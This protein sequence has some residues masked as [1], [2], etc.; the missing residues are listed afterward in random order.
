MQ[1]FGQHECCPSRVLLIVLPLSLVCL[2]NIFGNTNVFGVFQKVMFLEC[3]QHTCNRS[4]WQCVSGTFFLFQFFFGFVSLGWWSIS[5]LSV[6]AAE[7]KHGKNQS[8]R[9]RHTLDKKHAG[10]DVF[11]RPCCAIFWSKASNA[12]LS[13]RKLFI[14][15][16]GSLT[17]ISL[18]HW[19]LFLY[20]S[21]FSLH[22]SFIHRH[23]LQLFIAM[24]V[25][26]ISVS[27]IQSSLD[28]SLDWQVSVA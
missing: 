13:I 12:V 6:F 3:R 23:I 22:H 21:F 24:V 2:H 4:L 20:H 7:T 9:P 14:S 8:S 28:R 27:T 15:S 26:A 10:Y 18:L 5:R 25:R 1:R 19:Y 16:S 17:L 11:W